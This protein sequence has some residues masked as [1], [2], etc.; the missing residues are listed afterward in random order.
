MWSKTHMH[1]VCYKYLIFTVMQALVPDCWH[2]INGKLQFHHAYKICCASERRDCPMPVRDKLGVQHVLFPVTF[3]LSARLRLSNQEAQKDFFRFMLLLRS[4]GIFLVSLSCLLIVLPVYK[5]IVPSSSTV[6]KYAASLADQ[7]IVARSAK[8]FTMYKRSA[9]RVIIN[10][11]GDLLVRPRPIEAS[12]RLQPCS[13]SVQ[14]HL[15]TS[16]AQSIVSILISQ[17]R[18]TDGPKADMESVLKLIKGS[19][20]FVVRLHLQSPKSWVICQ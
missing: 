17:F 6:L 8:F 5:L 2:I 3:T 14:Q 13:G 9:H 19:A 12:L 4:F 20:T 7:D 18:P 10:R 16:Y 15:L 1:Q 11:K